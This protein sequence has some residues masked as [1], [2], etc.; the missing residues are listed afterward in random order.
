MDKRLKFTT[1]V[2]ILV[3]IAQGMAAQQRTL[4]LRDGGRLTYPNNWTL[5]APF[6]LT[7]A[8][9]TA[10]MYI[11]TA[12]FQTHAKAIR[13]LEAIVRETSAPIDAALISGWPAVQRTRTARLPQRDNEHAMRGEAM[14]SLRVTTAIAVGDRVVRLETYLAPAADKKV[15]DEA[16]AIGRSI[17]F[18]TRASQTNNQRDLQR[19]RGAPRAPENIPAAPMRPPAATTPPLDPPAVFAIAGQ[20]ELEMAASP[21]GQN[22]VI[23]SNSGLAVSNNS[24]VAY[25][26][27][28]GNGSIQNRPFQGSGQDLSVTIGQSGR[29]YAAF[30]GAPPAPINSTLSIGKSTDNTGQSFNFLSNAVA[31]ANGACM[32]DQGHIAADPVSAPDQIYGVY[33]NFG[34]LQ[35]CGDDCGSNIAAITCSSDGGSTWLSPPINVD[36]SS[37]F[38]RVDVGRDGMV[39]VVYQ[40][41]SEL[42]LTKY[43][44]CSAGLVRQDD[45]PVIVA[46]VNFDGLCPLAGLD[47][48]NNRNTISSPMIAP[49]DLDSRHVY[50]A[51]ADHTAANNDDV[52]VAES[53]DGG[54]TWPRRINV[55]TPTPA[56]RFMPWVCTASS[57]AMVSWYDRRAA[58]IGRSD[59]T[60]YFAGSIDSRRGVLTRGP[61]VNLSMNSDPQ[62]RSG[63]PCGVDNASLQTTCPLPTSFAGQCVSTPP[64][65][66]DSKVLCDLTPGRGVCLRAGETC[67]NMGIGCPKYGDYNGN[68]CA[69]GRAFFAWASATRP[70]GVAAAPAGIN[71][72]ADS[73]LLPTITVNKVVQPPTD[74]GVFD[75]AIDGV[76]RARGI[77]GGGS[78]GPL[79][80]APGSHDVGENGATAYRSSYSGD[81]SA[82]LHTVGATYGNGKTCTITN[83]RIPTTPCLD[84]CDARLETCMEASRQDGTPTRAMCMQRFNACQRA[85][86]AH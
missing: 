17:V 15:A 31:C 34:P 65:P 54:L 76:T 58:A 43:S 42:R 16:I 1:R 40:V 4:E 18:Q 69:S 55:N 6:E 36:D 51:Y 19:L 75:I 20:G 8:E 71:I 64:S 49:D 84:L 23:A 59:L 53:N 46:D 66:L 57:V 61:E 29:F 28:A 79:S 56:R 25:A 26:P 21:D 47:R 78:S 5:T 74:H 77:A 33:R 60:D 68:A 27:T 24:G 70:L 52:I 80:V 30:I 72:F 50:I 44:S 83:T 7:R 67:Q 73:L 86:R 63:F 13:H 45:F 9:M 62:C 38:P 82:A 11:A 41:E 14:H 3:V 12:R 32:V 48:C 37:D 35:G 81:C 10:R 85:C 22:V 2:L 39:Y